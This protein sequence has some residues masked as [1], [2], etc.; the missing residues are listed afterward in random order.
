MIERFVSTSKVV[1]GAPH[2]FG[3]VRCS[4]LD[5]NGLEAWERPDGIKVRLPTWRPTG[6]H[7]RQSW[8]ADTSA[9][10]TRATELIN[11]Q[12]DKIVRSLFLGA[13]FVKKC[14]VVT[15]ASFVLLGTWTLPASSE[16]TETN[17]PRPCSAFPRFCELITQEAERTGLDPALVDAVIKVESD[18]SPDT[19]GAAGEIGLMQVRPSTA[20]LLGFVGTDQELAEPAMNIRLGVTYLAKAWN[21][22]QGD[23]CRALMKYRAGHGEELMTPMSVEYCRRAR[24]HL[25]VQ[26]R[27]VVE[28]TVVVGNLS[29]GTQTVLRAKI[30]AIDRHLRG[31]AFWTVHDARVK[32]LTA[33]V[34]QRWAQR[35]KET[36]RKLLICHG[37]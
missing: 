2:T 37:C 33:M 36:D 8:S 7:S 12:R 20:R 6:T 21:L 10:G 16:T 11:S 15:F 26:G 1:F 9:P 13:V 18:Y 30:P 27:K 23:L 17:V 28:G 25:S 35:D 4:G 29:A 24:E 22:A 19:I 32:A 5:A 34:R 31:Q 14:R 3:W